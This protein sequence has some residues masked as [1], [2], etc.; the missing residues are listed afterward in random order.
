MRGK[1]LLHGLVL[2]AIFG[3][4]AG[5]VAASQ[6]SMCPEAYWDTPGVYGCPESERISEPFPWGMVF[7]IFLMVSILGYAGKILTG[8]AWKVLTGATSNISSNLTPRHTDN[9]QVNIYYIVESPDQVPPNA[10]VRKDL[11][12]PTDQGRGG[13]P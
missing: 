10:K 11:R 1:I 5:L 2:L 3:S 4:V 9:R 8:I 6:T 13:T 12:G 7:G